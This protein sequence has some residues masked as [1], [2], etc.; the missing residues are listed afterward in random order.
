MSSCNDVELGGIDGS[1]PLGFLAALGTLVTLHSVGE[2]NAQLGWRRSHRWVPVISGVSHSDFEGLVAKGLYGKPVSEM[3]IK[4]AVEKEKAFEETKRNIKNKMVEIKKRGLKGNERKKAIEVEIH[5]LE[6]EKDTRRQH[7]LKAREL[8]VSR[9]ELGLGKRIDCTSEE[10]REFALF[11]LT[12]ASA[13]NRELLD[14]LSAF[15]SDACLDKSAIKSTPFC[16][17]HGSGH[18]DFLH[19]IDQLTSKV[20]ATKVRDTLFQP[21]NYEDEGLSM[22]WDPIEDRQYALMDRDPTASDNRSRTVW[23]ANLL[24]YRALV[25]FPSAPK[26]KGLVTTGWSIIANESVLTWPIWEFFASPDAIR[27]MLQLHE[28]S[29]IRPDRSNLCNLGIVGVFR[30]RC[31]RVAGAGASYKVNFSPAREV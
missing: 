10:F 16:F 30:A 21:W 19:T 17:I 11:S 2:V 7:W 1:N 8:V 29:A 20:T 3:G 13:T 6:E 14:L 12:S 22:R 25:L 15:G 27:S 18:Q 5:P 31:I 23:M 9:S 26:R 24:A 28:L 4:H